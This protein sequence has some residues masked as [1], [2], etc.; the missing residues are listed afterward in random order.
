MKKNFKK[1]KG[2]DYKWRKIKLINIIFLIKVIIKK[3][4]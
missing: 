2:K 3:I 4:F 1:L